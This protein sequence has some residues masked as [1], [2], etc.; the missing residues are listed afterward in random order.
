MKNNSWKN[1]I[2]KKTETYYENDIFHCDIINNS[3]LEFH[4]KM[5]KGAALNE[6][7]HHKF[8]LAYWET[9]YYKEVIYNSLK[10]MNPKESIILDVGCGDG[11]FTEYLLE[12]GFERIIAT[13][14]HL[15]PLQ[16]LAKSISQKDLND[17]V[18]LINCDA[19]S[20]PIYSG[21]IDAV[22][23]FGVYYYMGIDFEKGI[24][25]ALRCLCN[26][27]ILLNS[28]PDLEGSIF[29]SLYFESIDD[30]FENFFL[31]RFKEEQGETKFKFRLFSKDEIELILNNSGF[32]VID[33]FGLSLLP[34]ILRIKT[35]RGD[36]S[37]S[38]LEK[39]E[40]KLWEVFDYFN[41]NNSL[42]KHVIWLSEKKNK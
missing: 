4:S 15:V 7:Q 42:N 34:S 8:H 39:N 3:G 27:G 31:R 37:I 35:A 22:I 29:K 30:V 18:L 9:K 41:K 13:D 11:R 36:I 26:N 14:I 1:D 38:E 40:E 2:L 23:A 16:S 10:K 24:N 5:K 20:T 6:L 21:K 32:E 28:E 12:M 17:K 25:E 19:K 33:N